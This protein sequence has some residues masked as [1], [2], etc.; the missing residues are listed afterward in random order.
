MRKMR[1]RFEK[2]IWLLLTLLM[3]A[4]CAK[5]SHYQQVVDREL[6]SGVKHNRLFLG[7]TLGMSKKAF[8]AHAWELNKKHLLT[9]GAG[10]LSIR[11][12]LDSL[13]TPAK[14]NFY[15][16][17]YHDKI[18]LMKVEISYAGWAPWNRNLYADSLEQ[19][20][21]HLFSRW[22]GPGFFKVNGPDSSSV[23]VKIDGNRQIAMK[24]TFNQAAVKVLF[25]DLKVEREIHKKNRSKSSLWSEFKSLF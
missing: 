16:E 23:Y 13:K 8:Y 20:L 17:F 7:F 2:Q 6:A 1:K 5:K 12:N 11:Y 25:S 21:I 19:D 24:P 9:A 3:L 10:N 4:G 14:M 22:Y 15:P 18:S